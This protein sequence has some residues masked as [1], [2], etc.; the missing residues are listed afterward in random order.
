MSRK[1]VIIKEEKREGEQDGL[2]QEK[3]PLSDNP[4]IRP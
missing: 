4:K 3:P 2:T 1:Y